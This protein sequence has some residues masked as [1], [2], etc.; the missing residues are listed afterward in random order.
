M[1]SVHAQK[2]GLQEALLVHWTQV[3]GS[4]LRAKAPGGGNEGCS[5]EAEG[6]PGVGG[7]GGRGLPWQ[8]RAGVGVEG[9]GRKGTPE[10][11]GQES[12]Q[13]LQVA[14]GRSPER[15]QGCRHSLPACL[16]VGW[17]PGKHSVSSGAPGSE[18]PEE[19]LP[20]VPS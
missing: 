6:L 12:L 1:T 3:E 9:A 8:S 15:A 10:G 13:E 17:A 18:N 2:A 16:S 11:S 14:P 19:E 20:S 5:L 4:L 7:G